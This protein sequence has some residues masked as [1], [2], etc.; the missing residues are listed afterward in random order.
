LDEW[1]F[2]WQVPIIF[3]CFDATHRETL[4]PLMATR[5]NFYKCLTGYID[6][7]TAEH[8]RPKLLPISKRRNHIVYRATKLPYWFGSHGQLKHRISGIVA[9]HA[10]LR[11]L[12]CDMSTRESDTI[13]GDTWIDFLA[14]GKTVIGCESG[15]SVLDRRGEVKSKIQVLLAQDGKLPFDGVSAQLPKG[16]DDYSFFAISPRHL[17]S[18]IARTCQVLI[19]G[20][21]DGILK[22][23]EHYI[24]LKRD[25]S[26]IDEV[27]EKLTDDKTL[28]CIA[29][30]AYEEVYLSRHYSYKKFAL[31]IDTAISKA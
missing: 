26:N 1:L 19:E 28:Q 5:A 6:D 10:G 8:I 16:W 15:S 9:E 29:D 22:P 14:S 2:E 13:I 24:P 12:Q 20:K 31:D 30:R 3:S 27:L 25:F 17:E 18:V 7:V 11:G 4:Y 23:N 21:Y